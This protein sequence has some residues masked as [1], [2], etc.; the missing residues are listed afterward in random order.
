MPTEIRFRYNGPTDITLLLPSDTVTLATA[1][2]DTLILQL[3]KFR[4]QM[5][6][7]ISRILKDGEHTLGIVDPIWQ[8]QPAIDHK[9]LF[10]RHP[11][12]GWMSFLFPLQ[13]AKKLAIALSIELPSSGQPTETGRPH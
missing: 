11:G 2:I 5:T 7:E 1:D 4:K 12:F 6:P 3:A 10:A 9:I 13:E 8:A